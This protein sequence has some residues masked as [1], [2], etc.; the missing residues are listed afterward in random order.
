MSIEQVL[1]YVL[2]FLVVGSA[3]FVVATKNL[4]RSIFVFF[5]TLFAIAGIYVFALADFIALTQV[6]IYVGGVLVLMLFAFLLS[7]KELLNNLQV[8]KTRFI[9]IHHLPGLF[10]A[11]LFL[12]I[13]ASVI[14]RVDVDQLPWIQDS[15]GKNMIQPEDNTT[16]QIGI[17]MMTKYLLPF[18]VISVLL[19]MALIG[20]AHL[21][22]KEK[23][24]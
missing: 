4:I 19:M 24:E 14:I 20:A 3:L 18:E 9:A 5:I 13:L 7:N 12:F 23:T 21:S 16:H 1:F 8:L 10:V 2:G 22:R 6:V 11:V 15:Y 17:L